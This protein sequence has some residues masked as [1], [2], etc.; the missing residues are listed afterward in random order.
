M[1][2]AFSKCLQNTNQKI[3]HKILGK[4]IRFQ[5]PN[6]KP[7]SSY[8]RKKK[9]WGGGGGAEEVPAPISTFEN[10]LDIEAIPTKCGHLLKYAK[11]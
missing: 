8:A 7:C 9:T 5:P 4:V 1:A 6:I 2:T 3:P 11:P 10:F